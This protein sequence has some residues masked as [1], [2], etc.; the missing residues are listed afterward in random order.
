M[1]QEM[2]QSH[3]YKGSCSCGHVNYLLSS[4]LKQAAFI[5][6]SDLSHCEFCKQYDGVWIS[7]ANG[8]LE[9]APEANTKIRHHGERQVEFHFCTLCDELCFALYKA[10]NKY[11]SVIRLHTIFAKEDEVGG[12]QFTDFRGETTEQSRLRR[13]DKWTPTHVMKKS[14]L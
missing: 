6:R 2:V 7:D 3:Q 9:I 13:M 12:I 11:F 10:E 8:V 14:K 4:N 5:P 1:I